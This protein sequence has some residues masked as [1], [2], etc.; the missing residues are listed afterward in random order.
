MVVAVFVVACT[1]DDPKK[2]VFAKLA[3]EAKP[4]LEAIQPFAR[5]VVR[6]EGMGPE[7]EAAIVDACRKPRAELQALNDIDFRLGGA[8]PPFGYSVGERAG[9]LLEA[10]QLYCDQLRN[11]H[12]CVQFCVREWTEL[13]LAIEHFRGDAAAHGVYVPDLF[14]QL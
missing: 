1:A 7:I 9:Y 12:E 6:L 10:Q 11:P 4:H 8:N 5:D 2:P 13:A 14:H 3:K